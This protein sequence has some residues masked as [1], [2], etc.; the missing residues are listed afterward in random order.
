MLL[1]LCYR[2]LFLYFKPSLLC[3]YLSRCIIVCLLW[4]LMLQV[5][6]SQYH[7]NLIICD[8]GFY[9]TVLYLKLQQLPTVVLEMWDS[10]LQDWMVIK[11]DN[12]L[13]IP[14]SLSSFFINQNLR[15]IR[16]GFQFLSSK[17]SII[18]TPN[19][20][21]FWLTTLTEGVCSPSHLNMTHVPLLTIVKF[22]YAELKR[23]SKMAYIPTLSS[24]HQWTGLGQSGPNLMG[25][26]WIGS[27]FKKERK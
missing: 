26:A 10:V 18:S 22:L 6:I 3:I 1:F 16:V 14:F 24:P 12:L 7:T 11:S 27:G 9:F 17:F 15:Y 21:V 20:G 4:L 2:F 13:S 23:N 8:I 19:K 5:I 25:L